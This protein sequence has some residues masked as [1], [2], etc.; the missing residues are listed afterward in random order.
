MENLKTHINV[1]RLLIITLT[2]IF[3]AT[4][5]I[6]YDITIDLKVGVNEIHIY[7]EL[8]IF[9]PL[10]LTLLAVGFLYYKLELKIYENL[11][12]KDFELLNLKSKNFEL[13]NVNEILGKALAVKIS[14][15]FDAWQLT[16]T[17]KEVGL[18]IIKGFSTK[19]I[20]EFRATSE[21][22][23]REQASSIYQKAGLRN[24]AELVSFFIE[25][26]L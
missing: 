10:V 25:D 26:I 21:K 15:Q 7:H 18:F 22:T 8:G 24:R 6:L 2:I 19:E 1:K 9:I 13:S 3:M 23:V 17:E 5:L 11:T 20:G 14:I 16:K 12:I 4:C